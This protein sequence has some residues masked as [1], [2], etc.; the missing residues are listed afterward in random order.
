M[1]N[2]RSF[3]IPFI[4]DMSSKKARLAVPPAKSPISLAKCCEIEAGKL[5]G[6]AV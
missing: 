4:I 5:N 3:G 2:D 1:I 6:K